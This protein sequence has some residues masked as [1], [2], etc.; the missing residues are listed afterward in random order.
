MGFWQE[1]RSLLMDTDE[2]KVLK[3]MAT[4]RDEERNRLMDENYRLH[5]KIAHLRQDIVGIHNRYTR[6]IDALREENYALKMAGKMKSAMTLVTLRNSLLPLVRILNSQLHDDELSD[7][8]LNL[9]MS[10][11]NWRE[12]KLAFKDFN[13]Q[14]TG[15]KGKTG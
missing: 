12:I 15:K 13:A 8:T 14:W 9:A 3:S 6:E 2:Y 4:Y 7:S 5:E 1:F 11:R 10:W